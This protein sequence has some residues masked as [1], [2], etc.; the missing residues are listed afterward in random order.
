MDYNELKKPKGY[1]KRTNEEIKLGLTP[2]LAKKR[3][4]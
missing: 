1:F 4:K 3:R 2:A